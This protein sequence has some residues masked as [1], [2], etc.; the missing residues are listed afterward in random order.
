MKDIFGNPWVQF[1][2]VV[3]GITLFIS[4]LYG[5]FKSGQKN[6]VET[7]LKRVNDTLATMRAS[8]TTHVQ[9]LALRTELMNKLN[10]V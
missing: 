8:D 1:G 6:E 5:A 10:G 2:L 3:V 9:L 7:R 4:I